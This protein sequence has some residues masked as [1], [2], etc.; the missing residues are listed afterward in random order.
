MKISNNGIAL[1]QRQ[2]NTIPAFK[3][4]KFVQTVS[5]NTSKLASAAVTAVGVAAL[6]INKNKVTLRTIDT[7]PDGANLDYDVVKD[8]F[9]ECYNSDFSVKNKLLEENTV[10]DV[11][12]Y[13]TLRGFTL[14]LVFFLLSFDTVN[15]S[16]IT[17]VSDAGTYQVEHGFFS[18]FSATVACLFNIGPGF[19][20][21]S[22]YSCFAGYAWYSK[23]TLTFTMLIGRL[24]ILPV[25]ILF[26]PKTW[27]KI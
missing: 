24:E 21:V 22:A 11:F 2:N 4:S 7:V 12:S 19:D 25:L 5:N 9:E 8:M 17:I 10:N 1:P 23:L 3:S 27:K 6:A 15:G 14:V 16:L 26:S 18:N 13:F 20:G